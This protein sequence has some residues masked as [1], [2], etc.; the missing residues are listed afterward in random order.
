MLAFE[1]AEHGGCLSPTPDP[2]LAR[3]DRSPGW[4][5]NFALAIGSLLVTTYAA[6]GALGLLAPD[7]PAPECLRLHIER[8]KCEA[9]LAIGLPF[10]MRSRVEVIRSLEAKGDT[11]WPNFNSWELNLRGDTIL[12]GGRP[13]QPLGGITRVSTLY[14]NERGNYV[15]FV[16]DEYGFRNPPGLHST[17][18]QHV[19]IGDSFVQGYCIPDDSTLADLL[20]AD[21][22]RTL[23]LGRDN[24]GPLSQLAVLREY[25]APLE[26]ET[27]F[28][29]FFE[30]NDLRDFEAE[31]KRESLTR[32]LDPAY[33]AKLSDHSAELDHQLR[34]LVQTKRQAAEERSGRGRRNSDQ[35]AYGFL[36][37]VSLARLRLLV[38]AVRSQPARIVPLDRT[39]LHQVLDLAASETRSWGGRL[40][41]VYLPAWER[42]GQP[43]AANPH[44]D[45]VI[46]IAQSLRIPVIDVTPA[47][48]NA[49]DPLALFPFRLS[50]HYEPEGQRLVAEEIRRFI[51]QDAP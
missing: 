28:W 48:R 26:P 36:D 6:E 19:L 1:P 32:Y 15:R 44:R 49:P 46:E 3:P 20:R 27:V 29:F 12:I 22:P 40:I 9:A 24:H 18:V 42:F 23:N 8:D 30:G 5:V 16:S 47:F 11:V 2:A 13:V 17:P 45:S 31:K 43:E 51:Q 25:A 37:F 38:Q 41:L 21:Y 39:G 33:D 35:N 14:C 34:S 50:G 7:R 4:W 10:D